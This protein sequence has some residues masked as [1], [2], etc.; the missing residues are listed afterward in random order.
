[1]AEENMMFIESEDG[2]L[3]KGYHRGAPALI[4]NGSEFVPYKG[5]VP[6]P[7]GWGEEIDEERAKA[8]MA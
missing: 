2:G 6:K 1:M 3:F 8:L 4:W 7:E 5:S